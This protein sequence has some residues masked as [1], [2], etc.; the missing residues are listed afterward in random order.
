LSIRQREFL[1]G[2]VPAPAT[3]LCGVPWIDGDNPDTG[4]FCLVS[5][6]FKK[7]SPTCIQCGLGKS[8]TR[9]AQDIQVLVGDE[10]VALNQTMGSLEMEVSALIGNVPMYS[11]HEEPGLGTSLG[12]ELPAREPTLTD[13]EF[14]LRL[15]GQGGRINNDPI[16]AGN[17]RF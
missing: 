14:L 1:F 8:G 10:S 13:T 17:E 12:A 11:C 9:Y 5:E 16:R 6:D 2:D 4:A 7:L 3:R 15:S